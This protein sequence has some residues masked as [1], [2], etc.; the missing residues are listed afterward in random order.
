MC[1]RS[2]GVAAVRRSAHVTALV[3]VGLLGWVWPTTAADAAFP[4]ANGRIAFASDRDGNFDVYVMS[5]DGSGQTRL[6]TD[7]AADGD[8]AWSPDGQKI[9]FTSSRAGNAN[10]VYVMSADGSGQTRLTTDPAADGDPAWSPDGQKIAFTSSLAGNANDVYVMSADGSS[11]TRLTTDAAGDVAPAWSPDGQKI[12]FVSYRNGNVDVYVMK[13]DGSGQTRLT[14]DPADDIWPAWSPDGNRITFASVRDGNYEVYAMSADGSGQTRLTSHAA[15]DGVSAWSPDG[16]KIVFESLRDGGF[17]VYVM[18]TD[19]S[20]VQ[21]LTSDPHSDRTP[22]WQPVVT[23]SQPVGPGRA[24]VLVPGLRGE[25][26]E[27]KGAGCE[28]VGD[29]F[30]E[31]CARLQGAKHPVY[32]PSAAPSG[33]KVTLSTRGAVDDNAQRLRD[34]LRDTRVPANALLVGHSM[35]GLIT[36]V[37]MSRYGAPAAGLVT[38]GT[39]HDGSFGADI[40]EDVEATCLFVV[41][42]THCGPLLPAAAAA[43]AYFGPLAIHDLTS[44]SRRADRL[45]PPGVPVTALAGTASQRGLVRF[46]GDYWSPSDGIVGR[47][48]AWGTHADLGDDQHVTRPELPLW[49]IRIL[50]QRDDPSKNLLDDPSAFEVVRDAA[51]RLGP[52][53]SRARGVAASDSPP[54]RS[55][56]RSTRPVRLTL[57]AGRILSAH[58]AARARV[59]DATLVA[60]RHA[61]AV[62]CDGV[63]V[64]A[65]TVLNKLF[66]LP[67]SALDCRRATV[68][69]RSPVLVTSNPAR[70]SATL[71]ATRSRV[72]VRVRARR[73]ITRCFVTAG[74]RRMA[75]RVR[76]GRAVGVVARRRLRRNSALV[77]VIGGRRYATPLPAA[78]TTR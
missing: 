76:R 53:T 73:R 62:R 41:L 31:L 59:H 15:S 70:V 61:F 12:A 74:R 30:R 40:L 63:D 55:A 32:V 1:R 19:G 18:N 33:N 2:N 43:D 38:L 65:L 57:T 5:A 26:G 27:V 45:S 8:P 42:P 36:R 75:V 35:G 14:T 60:A 39:P 37:A 69:A 20:G 67:T 77:A 44:G 25:T 34:W 3:A 28:G 23:S 9:A 11:Q 72:R 78:L 48:S 13:V 29:Y 50:V 4:G 54:A 17:D 10:D 58:Q 47:S 49:H 6:T 16:Q 71:A 68:A 51:A 24:I 22:D 52:V 21:R 7:P 46:L 56:A 66:A 64:P